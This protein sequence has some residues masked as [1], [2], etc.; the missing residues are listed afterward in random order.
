MT[1]SAKR[2]R[3]TIFLG[4]LALGTLVWSAVDQFGIP[5]EE[6]IDLFLT[7]VLGVLSVIVVAAGVAAVWFSLRWLL[8]DRD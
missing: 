2:Y 8:R 6:M 5:M 7:T 1:R 4:V 3:R